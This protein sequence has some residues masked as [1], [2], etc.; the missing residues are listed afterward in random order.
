[1]KLRSTD[2]LLFILATLAVA[3][4]IATGAPYHA[5][6]GAS[7]V[8]LALAALGLRLL[9][10]LTGD[11]SFGYGVF[12]GLGAYVFCVAGGASSTAWLFGLITAAAALTVLLATLLYLVLWR[13]HGV[14]FTLA[15]VCLSEMFR[16][17]VSS[18][19][20]T[21]GGDNGIH[22]VA[23]PAWITGGVAPALLFGGALLAAG[24]ACV[25][26]DRSWIGRIADAARQSPQRVSSLG[27]RPETARFL[28]RVPAATLAG[29]A[30]A[31]VATLDGGAHPGLFGWT[32]S[33]E[34]IT[35]ALLCGSRHLV[36]P[37]LAA[38]LIVWSKSWL[39][40]SWNH[41]PLVI[42]ALLVVLSRARTLRAASLSH[43]CV[44]R[45]A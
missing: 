29:A 40:G 6:L 25:A 10:R 22:G 8:A 38:C 42:G 4:L 37:V 16:I 32:S 9:L 19:Y 34:L 20:S 35:V 28:I 12:F 24:T 5:Y 30:G 2:N 21:L 33:G 18:A 14:Y 31:L 41:W 23:R 45:N 11:L 36:A 44:A 39:S 1:M 27:I 26:I 7:A 15:T 3:G 13:V 43:S 17:A